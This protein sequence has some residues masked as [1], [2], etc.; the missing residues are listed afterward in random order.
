MSCNLTTPLTLINKG[1]L[2]ND[3][4]FI[5]EI[6]TINHFLYLILYLSPTF[7]GNKTQFLFQ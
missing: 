3:I 1:V 4:N 5:I 2:V 6:N 7:C